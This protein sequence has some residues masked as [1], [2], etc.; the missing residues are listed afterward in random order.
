MTL[1]RRRSAQL[2]VA[3][4]AVVAATTVPGSPSAAVTGGSAVADGEHRFAVHLTDGVSHGCTGTLVSPYWILTAK[5]CV[6]NAEGPIKAQIGKANLTTST[7]H[8]RTIVRSVTHPTLNLAL[9]RV[10]VPVTDVAVPRIG[11]TAVA[12]GE[13]LTI[14]G[15]GRTNS[16]WV[17]RLHQATVAVTGVEAGTLAIASTT[18]DAPTTCKG[19]AGGP[20]IR[21]TA[22]GV[23]VVAVHSASY[24]GGCLGETAT[25]RDAVET[26]LDV[27]AGWIAATVAVRPRTDFNDDGKA[28]IAGIN[29]ADDMVLHT[30]DGAGKV[31]LQGLMW[32]G[33]GRW[34]G[35]HAFTAGDFTSDGFNDIAI[36]DSQN[37]M[38]LY[39]GDG[40][41]QLTNAGLMWTTG[42][43]WANH[44]AFTAGDFNGDS[45]L[46][47]AII[48]SQNSLRLYA[49]DGAGKLV[50]KPVMFGAAGAWVNHK[51]LAGG[52][53]DSDGK[54]DIAVIDSQNSMRLYSGDGTGKLVQKPV[55]FGAT[56]AWVNHRSF[57]GG[58]FDSDGKA[59]IA[60]LD[61]QNNLRLYAGDGAGKL[62]QKPTMSGASGSW[63]GWKWLAS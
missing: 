12:A 32:P 13:S 49:G 56:G 4:V 41:G 61:S 55:M 5:D 52:D 42:G 31:A 22:T 46:D 60:V 45:F 1:N 44:H 18:P 57:A 38:R 63:A 7:G 53:F 24:Q 34:A 58:D 62:I 19:D 30:G 27:A 11:A 17:G 36:I 35:S 25:R 16:T 29:P 9:S 26:R 10:A 59:D 40:T 50:Q 43:L 33:T 48:D 21:Q 28:D 8:D 51:A 39:T 14:L 23:E 15:Y 3:L 37:N 6:T 47:I 20:A 2:A 54:A